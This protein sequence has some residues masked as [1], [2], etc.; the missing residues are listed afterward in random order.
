VGAAGDEP[1]VERAV[2]GRWLAGHD[3]LV[4]VLLLLVGERGRGELGLGGLDESGLVLGDRNVRGQRE[5]G[6]LG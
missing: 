6:V 1:G 2:L 4:V 5:D 3:G